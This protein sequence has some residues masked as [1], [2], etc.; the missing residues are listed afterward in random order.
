MKVLFMGTPA[1]AAASLEALIDAGHDVRLVVTRPDAGSGRGLVKRA[2]AVKVVATSRGLTVVQPDSIAGDAFHRQAAALGADIMVVAAFGRILPQSLLD[3]APHGAV[4]VHASLLPKLRGASPI[5]WAILG[6]ERRTGITT[7]KMVRRLDAGDILM[8][9]GTEIGA[10][11]T[12]GQLESRLATMGGD[13]LVRTLAGLEAGTITPRPQDEAEVTWAPLLRKEDGVVDWS[14][15]ASEIARRVRAFDPW[16]GAWTSIDGTAGGRI[17]IVRA[18]AIEHAGSAS[19]GE[20]VGV[21]RGD[22]AQAGALVG[23]GDGTVLLVTE[24]QPAGRK[25]MPALAA[26]AGRYLREGGRLGGG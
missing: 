18:R 6:G 23:C 2:P 4:H 20:I 25:P 24:V 26:V 16:P 10:D 17:R 3:L 8:Q 11:E 22:A 5:V 15:P 13:L 19:P 1:F 21:R 7:M 14:R 12:A 9:S